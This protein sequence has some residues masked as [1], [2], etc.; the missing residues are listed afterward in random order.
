MAISVAAVGDLM[1][2]DSPICV[3]FGFHSRYT[4]DQSVDAV[5]QDVRPL[6]ADTDL[7]FGN[8]ETVL[9][10]HGCIPDDWHSTQLRG[11]PS[12]AR[13][14]R[15]AGFS[16]VSVANNHA[17]QHGHQAFYETLDVLRS[18]NILFC[19]LR[20]SA[21]W[22]SH[23]LIIEGNE[24][25]G[26]LGYS[27]RPRQYRFDTP[28]YAEGTANDIIADVARLSAHVDHVLV[29]LHW[30]EEFVKS[31][32]DQEVLLG[33][34]VVDAGASLVLGHH[35]HVVRPV[36]RYK[37]GLIAYSLGNFVSDMLWQPQL[38]EGLLLRCHLSGRGVENTRC[39]STVMSE[40][41]RI[42]VVSIEGRGEV[43]RTGI[44]GLT[45][46]A[47]RDM[48]RRAL[49]VQRLAAYR[50]ALVN[51]R[52]YPPPMLQQLVATTIKNKTESLRR[53]VTRRA[54]NGS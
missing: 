53:L 31:P 37:S 28:P 45:E 6:L 8:L 9:S 18:A 44:R 33:R 22:A 39:V 7:A 12:Y 11:H 40:D 21:P 23:P 25:V 32:S 5:F 52:R 27:L 29:S 16:V 48:S 49:N 4:D 24:R 26:V 34:A 20:G 2:G 13:A 51:I 10:L 50:Y 3:G 1:L 42:E 36:E 43:P 30:G 15:R 46:S 47:Y 35:P 41:L 14:L 17:V 54:R 19:G 38:C